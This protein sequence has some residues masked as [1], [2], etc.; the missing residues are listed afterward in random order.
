MSIFG[1][2]M[3][4]GHESRAIDVGEHYPDLNI[5]RMF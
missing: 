5:V 2:Q 3:G 1:L 4:D